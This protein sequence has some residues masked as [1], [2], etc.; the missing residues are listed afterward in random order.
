MKNTIILHA[1]GSVGD[2]LIER[3]ASVKK[4]V[5][6]KTVP[7]FKWAVPAAACLAAVI[8]GTII[9][10]RLPNLI[11]DP[12]INYPAI[13]SIEPAVDDSPVY[14]PDMSGGDIGGGND[15]SYRY[16]P[17]AENTYVAT[18]VVGQEAADDWYVNYYLSQPP[19]E[20]I[21]LPALYQM[22]NAFGISKDDLIRE[23]ENH[24]GSPNHLYEY[25][26]DALYQEE[27][28]M[29]Y[30]LRHPLAL[31]FDGEIYTYYEMRGNLLEAVQNIPSDV[32]AEYFALIE[33][34]SEA[35]E[36]LKELKDNIDAF[37]QSYET[38]IYP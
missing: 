17:I 19:L 3:A 10:S 15:I 7:W 31:Y 16:F 25:V 20:A 32:K 34:K 37:W 22:I 18:Q 36:T 11:D 8:A 5:R 13:S 12:D 2:D 21:A 33:A 14:N 38:G 4:T 26:I 28:L 1:I 30:L 24:I 27:A 9:L 29:M 6:G 35:D 23:N